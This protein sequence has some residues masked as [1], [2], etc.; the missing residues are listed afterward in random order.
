[1]TVTDDTATDRGY[2]PYFEHSSS[3]HDNGEWVTCQECV[4]NLWT[5]DN[6][7]AELKD[8]AN[9]PGSDDGHDDVG[10][11]LKCFQTI[12]EIAKQDETPELIARDLDGFLEARHNKTG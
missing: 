12:M 6:L 3:A 10:F 5:I 9:W 1:M 2:A 8:M 11:L 4:Q 7:A